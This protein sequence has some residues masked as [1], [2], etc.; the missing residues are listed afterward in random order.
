MI[1]QRLFS[2]C[3]M[4]F[5]CMW[6]CRCVSLAWF[7][8]VGLSLCESDGLF[9]VTRPCS[10]FES[11]RFVRPYKKTMCGVHWRVF[12]AQG[13]A[14]VVSPN[15]SYTGK[16]IRSPV[17]GYVCR[18]AGESVLC[19]GVYVWAMIVVMY[20]RSCDLSACLKSV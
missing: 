3:D 13:M 12:L 15:L 20:S 10:R 7:L 5:F 19:V 6:R 8:Y 11:G 2:L 14:V 18:L 4:V 17:N 16:R 1:P 9:L